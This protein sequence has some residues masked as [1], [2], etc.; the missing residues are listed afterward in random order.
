MRNLSLSGTAAF[1]PLQTS[2]S[3]MRRASKR[4]ILSGLA[5]ER[6]LLLG[7]SLLYQDGLLEQMLRSP[8]LLETELAEMNLISAPPAQEALG[9]VALLS[10]QSNQ[11]VLICRRDG[12]WQ[13]AYWPLMTAEKA[14]QEQLCAQNLL[15]L[16]A[17][18][19]TRSI[20]FP[21]S[22]CIEKQK[23][24]D[25]LTALSDMLQA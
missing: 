10:A 16:A 8:A 20:D 24:S 13:G 19:A 5:T 17:D 23:I 14:A 9:C 18:D 22:L 7:E 4:A 12:H 15:R 21:L 3:A 25:I 6:Y 1:I 2:L 11:G